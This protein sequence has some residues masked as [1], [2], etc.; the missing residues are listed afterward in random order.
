VTALSKLLKECM[1]EYAMF[2]SNFNDMFKIAFVDPITN[3]SYDLNI[4][5][6]KTGKHSY[7]PRYWII[8]DKFYI[9]ITLLDDAHAKELINYCTQLVYINYRKR[10][11]PKIN[12]VFFKKV[13][14]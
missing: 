3:K 11:Q 12:V 14:K 13:N 7:S 1:P 2:I 5:Y 9:D 8:D 4:N 10:N 6:K